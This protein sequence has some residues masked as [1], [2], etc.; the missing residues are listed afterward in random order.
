MTEDGE[1]YMLSYDNG[2]EA[3]FMPG[4]THDFFVLSKYREELGRDYRKIV[5]FLCTEENLREKLRVDSV[6]NGHVFGKDPNYSSD[7][8]REKE[9]GPS[10][11]W[12]SDE[13]NRESGKYLSSHH[14]E[15][16]EKKRTK[17][18]DEETAA[19]HMSVEPG[20]SHGST[21]MGET[22]VPLDKPVTSTLC[23][24]ASYETNMLRRRSC[25]LC[26]L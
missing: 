13:R 21:C 4:Q 5:L 9:E 14:N 18:L 15:S 20:V 16:P 24:Q 7:E 1:N 10:K 17:V 2:N 6:Y 11:V 22:E 26:H 23:R 25:L 12:E 3:M 19:S 8:Y